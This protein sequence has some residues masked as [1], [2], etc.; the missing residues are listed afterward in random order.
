[1]VTYYVCDYLIGLDLLTA[2][3]HN[4]ELHVIIAL[5]TVHGYTHT[6]VLSLH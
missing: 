1:M 6:K 2:L 5:S 4:S 3:T